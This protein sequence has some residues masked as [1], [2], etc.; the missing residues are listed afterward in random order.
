MN[1]VTV[2]FL[3]KLSLICFSTVYDLWFV[4]YNLSEN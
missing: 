1:D 2:V 3:Y 4:L